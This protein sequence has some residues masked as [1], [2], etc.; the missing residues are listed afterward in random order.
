MKVDKDPF[1]FFIKELGQLHYWD[2][3]HKFVIKDDNN[4][5]KI[6]WSCQIILL[7]IK[8]VNNTEKCR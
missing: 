2:K 5:K 6:I 7:E 4:R 8:L 3:I 1:N